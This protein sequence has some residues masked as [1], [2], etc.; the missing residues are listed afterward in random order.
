MQNYFKTIESIRAKM[1]QL[2][3]PSNY[4]HGIKGTYENMPD[5]ILMLHRNENHKI[6][7]AHDSNNLYHKRYVLTI[8][9]HQAGV[10]CIN[11]VS[12]PIEENY[13][14][15]T[16]PFQ[17]HYYMV[18][19]SDFDWLVITFEANEIP[20][21]MYKSF[22]LNSHALILVDRLVS[23]YL[24]CNENLCFNSNSILLQQYLNCLLYEIQTSE[25]IIDASAPF[26]NENNHIL[27]FEK[28]NGYIYK[29][30]QNPNL[31]IQSIAE[32]HYI[33]IALVHIIFQK[34]LGHSPGKYIRSVRIKHAIKLL[35]QQNFLISEIAERTGFSSVA[36]FSRCFHNETN[37]TPSEY[38]KKYKENK[39]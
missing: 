11:E 39:I 23:V 31:S 12:L 8:N 38:L 34:T 29:N 6:T 21:F 14:V 30:I 18:K 17:T 28:I 19:Q 36:V 20:N 15:I 5:N 10:V 25:N 2:K 37:L 16:Y 24:K 22:Q 35:E 1:K 4:F 26:E 27:L 7:N 13:C 9:L 32:T 3:E 33:S